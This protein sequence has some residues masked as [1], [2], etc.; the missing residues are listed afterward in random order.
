MK[1]SHLALAL[2]GFLGICAAQQPRRSSDEEIR[3]AITL[4]PQCCLNCVLPL[5]NSMHCSLSNLTTFT[6]CFC[7]KKKIQRKISLCTGANCDFN[8]LKTS[9]EQLQVICAGL[10]I[11]SRQPTIYAITTISSIVVTLFVALR[12]HSN[13]QIAKKFW[14]D[15]GFLMISSIFFLAFQCLTMWGTSYGFGLHIWTANLSHWAGLLLFEWLWEII[16]IIV[17][18]MTKISVL[19]L[20]HRIFPQRWFR[21]VITCLICIMFL[22][23]IAFCAVIITACKPIKSFWR[24]DIEGRCIDT[25]AVG[26]VGAA[27]SI[28]EDVTFLLL[29]VPLIWRLK[30][31]PSRKIGIIL[32]LTIG[33]IACAA[34]VVRLKYLIMYN[35][36]W[37]QIWENFTLVVLSQLE[38]SLSIICV[39][40]PAIRLL[41][42]RSKRGNGSSNR[43]KTTSAPTITNSS[44]PKISDNTI[45]SRIRSI[46]SNNT[47][48]NSSFLPWSSAR[49]PQLSSIYITSHIELSDNDPSVSDKNTKDYQTHIA[50]TRPPENKKSFFANSSHMEPPGIMHVDKN[51][52]I[53][54]PLQKLT[55]SV[56]RGDYKTHSRIPSDHVD[57]P[58]KTVSSTKSAT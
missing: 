38:L 40:F 43:S 58:K 39:C 20:Y 53:I 14:W 19:L 52:T 31:K 2:L 18:T 8:K 21:R 33:V 57:E 25:R 6:D 23:C 44:C 30:L 55:D 34:S 27:F 36:T 28:G 42:S 56:L 11:E 1:L 46:I 3:T 12:C 9:E 41:F 22:H 5:L 29:P 49:A 35:Q 51:G 17:Q 32:I 7:A 4:L 13:F 16:Y 15:D 24:K 26:V 54:S 10:P 48:N 50:A 37:D 47:S 45:V